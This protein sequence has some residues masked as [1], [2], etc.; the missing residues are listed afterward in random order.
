[1]PI[2]SR[3]KGAQAEREFRDKLRE[4]GYSARRGQQF[5]GSPDSP[6][7][8]CEDLPNIHWEVKRVENLSLYPAM[9]Q[10]IR[11]SGPEKTPVVAHRRN[12]KEWLVVMRADD[13]FSL[14]HGTL[15]EA[16]Q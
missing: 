2:N 7:V 8:V 9:E 5:S 13:F 3:A 16:K 4:H 14:L 6:D 10:A 15:A 11:D 12:G 1:M